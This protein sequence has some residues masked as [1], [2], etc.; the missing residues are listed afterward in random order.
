M[1]S[2]KENQTRILII[3]LSS[4]EPSVGRRCIPI[5]QSALTK[6]GAAVT[7]KDIREFP[8]IWVDNRKLEEYPPAFV[9]LYL[10]AQASDGVVLIVPIYCYTMSGVAKSVT[11]IIGDALNL[12][13]V[14]MVTAAGSTRSHLAIRD[15][16][17]SMMFEQ[18]T[19]C[20]PETVQATSEMLIIEK[21]EPNSE[22]HERL[23]AL[24]TKFTAFVVALKPFVNQHTANC[25]EE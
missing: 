17:S 24:A 1:T 13:P 18:E 3:S 14:A 8:P 2:K 9:D 23:T 19:I 7:L 4:S 25:D 6:A 12:K 20:F 15:L 10:E 21:D 11:E 16:M 22:L 5:L